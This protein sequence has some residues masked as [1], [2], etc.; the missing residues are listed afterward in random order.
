MFLVCKSILSNFVIFP[1][2]CFGWLGLNGAGKSTTFRMLTGALR[3]T[4]GSF[5]VSPDRWPA[6][7]YCPQENAIDPLLTAREALRVHARVR[8]VRPHDR[9]KVRGKKT[10]CRTDQRKK[11]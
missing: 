7:G 5:A 3:P 1:R 11:L 6:A 2:Q 9:V 4:A 8:G 10:S